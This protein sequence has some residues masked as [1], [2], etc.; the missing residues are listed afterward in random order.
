MDHFYGTM[1]PILLEHNAEHAI[2]TI[3]G[4]W[5]VHPRKTSFIAFV[6]ALHWSAI[7]KKYLVS[8]YRYNVSRLGNKKNQ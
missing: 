3:G 8:S 4:H 2:C 7:I 6:I 5:T 1:A